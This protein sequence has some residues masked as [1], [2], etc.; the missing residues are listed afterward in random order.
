MEIVRGFK[1]K[2]GVGAMAKAYS[3]FTDLEDLFG[4]QPL[5]LKKVRIREGKD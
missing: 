5:D 4:L 2:R 1:H 3:D